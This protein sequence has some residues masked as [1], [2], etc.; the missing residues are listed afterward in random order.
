MMTKSKQTAEN[1]IPP[2]DDKFSLCFWICIVVSALAVVIYIW[3]NPS[4]FIDPFKDQM[5][6]IDGGEFLMGN[7]IEDDKDF[8]ASDEY[9]I[10]KVKLDTFY[11]GQYEVS[12]EQWKEIMKVYPADYAETLCKKCPANKVSWN[13][14][15]EFIKK[16]NNLIDNNSKKYRL[17]T[18]AEW[19]YAARVRGKK[20]RFGNGENMARFED[21]NF[22][23]RHE[24]NPIA[25]HE[26]SKDNI[27]VLKPLPVDYGKRN[28]LK[29]YNMSGNVY[30]FCEDWYDRYDI[31]DSINPKG[32][33]QSPNNYKVIR[34]GTFKSEASVLECRVSSR[35]RDGGGGIKPE[36]FYESVGFRLARD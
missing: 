24:G 34:G 27:T 18:E 31:Q 28:E 17:P 6:K 19:E 14:V 16:L 9:P 12:N 20:V 22:N 36:S 13:E 33:I 26:K 7:V 23:S 21:I 3:L 8:A 29:L 15:Q 5:V 11:L 32:P 4:K 2:E 30:E 35:G 10:H 25:I 1:N